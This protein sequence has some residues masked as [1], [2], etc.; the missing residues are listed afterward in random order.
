M[1]S[2]L[3]NKE[4]L[5]SIIMNCHNSDLY[6][7][8][9][10]QSVLSQTYQNWELIFWDNLSTDD[11]ANIFNSFNDSRLKYF[12]SPTFVKLGE[13]R[14]Q[15]I[16]KAT[17]EFIA[18]LDC[19]DLWMPTKLEKQIPL[20][21]NLEVGIVICDSQFFNK[22]GD[23]KRGCSFQR[24]PPSRGNVFADLIK[25]YFISLE[26]AVIRASCLKTLDGWFDERFEVIEEYDLFIR[27]S[28]HF[29]LDYVDEVLAKW[30]IHSN[31]LTWSLPELFP[32]EKRLFMEKI[33]DLFPNALDQ[34]NKE[35][36]ILNSQIVLQEAFTL[37]RAKRGSSAR[38]LLFPIIFQSPKALFAYML[39]VFLPYNLIDRLNR[40]RHGV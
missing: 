24:T 1:S 12:L 29:S 27:L 30:R 17:G 18:F 35:F 33:R 20:F 15:A 3:I 9:A 16:R 31:S 23:I 6:L 38:K 37:W 25:A 7:T 36:E 13:A 34:Y 32:R 39:S 11:S 28:Y 4:S 14:N 2:S 8:Q 26:T 10:I 22:N 21:D 5:V 40:I 19:D